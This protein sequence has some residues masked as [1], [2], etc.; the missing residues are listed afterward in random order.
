MDVSPEEEWMRRSLTVQVCAVVFL[1]VI[2][3]CATNPATGKKELMLV[4]ESQEIA[5][6][7]EED[8]KAVASF[9][10][11][12]DPALQDYVASLG[13]SIAAHSERPDLPWTFRLVD[14]AAVNAFALPGGF[15]YMTRGIMGYLDSEAELV[16]V[17]GHEVGHVTARHSAAQMS[18]QQLVSVGLGIGMIASKDLRRYG[19]LAQ[20]GLGLLFL[21]FGR[22]DE[23]EADTLGLRYSKRLG[24]DAAEGAE[25]FRM[26]DDLSA[27]SEA[28]RVPGWLST[29]PDPGDRY[30]RLL[31]AARQ[32]GAD[33][34]YV[35][36]EA[37]LKRLD[38]IVFGE[39]PRE[40]FFRDG[41]FYHPELR[42]RYELPR[43]FEGQNTKQAVWAVSPNGDAVFQVT[44]AA[45]DSPDGPARE[46]F[47]SQGIQTLDSSRTTVNGLSAIV[48]T[49]EATQ[50]QTVLRGLAG[51]VSLQGRVY[52]LVGY[53][54]RADW[55]RYSRS[56]SAAV[57]SFGPLTERWAL[58]V[59]PRRIDV[60][61][62]T[63]DMT[64]EQFTE[65]YPSTV[66]ASTVA[67]IN[68]VHEGDTFAA[69]RQAKRVIGGEGRG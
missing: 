47:G 31:A 35:R 10:V 65:A 69:G 62:P 44:L 8:Q 49:F 24:Y 50:N 13:H 29:H 48:G 18:S 36:R 57:Q 3:A 38:G 25:A 28:G 68:Q 59:E 5:M 55:N 42:F 11:Y 54:G 43:G 7:K 16:M 37:Y 39:N 52:R 23:N 30:R 9:G 2:G 17:M 22:D 45:G 4:S 58:D 27:R 15:V 64:L 41:V 60:V 51:F 66:D 1:A 61:V 53:T 33:D 20:L 21:K 6:G 63:R 56:F 34:G 19:D 32:Q 26:L 14:D 40:G 46:F 67:I 12:E